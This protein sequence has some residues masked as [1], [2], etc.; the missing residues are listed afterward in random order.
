MGV[1]VKEPLPLDANKVMGRGRATADGYV[2]NEQMHDARSHGLVS[3]THPAI[4]ID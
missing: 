2:S 4:P 3:K 1:Q